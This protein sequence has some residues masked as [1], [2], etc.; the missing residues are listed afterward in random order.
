MQQEELKRHN[1]TTGNGATVK[2]TTD[3]GL[4]VANDAIGTERNEFRR[5]LSQQWIW[6][7]KGINRTLNHSDFLEW[8]RGLKPSVM[9][10]EGYFKQFANSELSAQANF[11][12]ILIL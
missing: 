5:A 4:F 8:F 12:K 7:K 11:V 1:N 3:G 6:F 10:F 2:L 9:D